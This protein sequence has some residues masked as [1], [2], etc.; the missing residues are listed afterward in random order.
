MR[1]GVLLK[2]IGS[3]WSGQQFTRNASEHVSSYCVSK[4]RC[5]ALEHGSLG[6]F[7][8][9]E[10]HCRA[11]LKESLPLYCTVCF[12][13]QPL[14]NVDQGS[15]CVHK[16]AA[17]MSAAQWPVALATELSMRQAGVTFGTWPLVPF[18][19][20][21]ADHSIDLGIGEP[22]ASLCVGFCYVVALS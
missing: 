20:E 15:P 4:P 6:A 1:F 2:A 10:Q 9:L 5:R 22:C 12:H 21:I 18:V 14:R 16:P 11:P 3:C 17:K 7:R 19:K 8:V 13:R